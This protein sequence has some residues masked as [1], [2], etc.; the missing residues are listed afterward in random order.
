MPLLIGNCVLAGVELLFDELLFEYEFELELP[1]RPSQSSISV[2]KFWSLLEDVVDVAA[3]ALTEVNTL[4]V[5]VIA[6]K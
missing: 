6:N 1:S 5:I 4:N 2:I 3:F